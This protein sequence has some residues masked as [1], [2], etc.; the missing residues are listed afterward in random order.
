MRAGCVR[1]F[2][3]LHSLR[4][5]HSLYSFLFLMFV[6]LRSLHTAP[7]EKCVSEWNTNEVSGLNETHERTLR[8]FTC[9]CLVYSPLVIWSERTELVTSN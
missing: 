7:R 1:S 3:S 6:S 5:S 4:L 2:S 8:S 9:V